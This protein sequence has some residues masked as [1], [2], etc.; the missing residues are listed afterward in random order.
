MN[1]TGG[2]AVYLGSLG[3]VEAQVAGQVGGVQNH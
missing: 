3:P 1:E 2:A